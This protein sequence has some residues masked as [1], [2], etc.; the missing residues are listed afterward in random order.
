M[1]K[2]DVVRVIARKT[3]YSQGTVSEIIDTLHGVMKEALRK[4]EA[5]TFFDFGSFHTFHRPAG[6]VK[7]IKTG[8][9][10]E[11]AAR[12]VATF[13]PA[14]KLKRAVFNATKEGKLRKRG[15]K[16]DASYDAAAHGK[17]G[18]TSAPATALPPV[19]PG[20]DRPAATRSIPGRLQSW[21]CVCQQCACAGLPRQPAR[22]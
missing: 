21:E 2:T 19:L 6:K 15:K 13:R 18:R 8:E 14:E 9:L 20:M 3:R 4:G 5:V 22:R 16:T 17:A 10:V 12:G 11:Y 7:R 1:H